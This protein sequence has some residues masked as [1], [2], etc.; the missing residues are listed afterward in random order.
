MIKKKNGLWSE[1]KAKELFAF[2]EE[3]KL[4]H[5]P[6]IKAFDNYAAKTGRKQ[7]SVRNYYYFHLRHLEKKPEEATQLGVSLQVH[8]KKVAKKFN[9]QEEQKLLSDIAALRKEGKS[10]RKAC[11]ILA[12]NDIS[13]MIRLQNKVRQLFKK[14]AISSSQKVIQMPQKKNMV[15]E[16]EISSLFVGLVKMVQKNA[17]HMAESKIEHE[18]QRMIAQLKQAEQTAQAKQHEIDMLK[19]QTLKATA[20]S[21]NNQSL[22]RESK[23][24]NMLNTKGQATPTKKARANK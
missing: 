4:N 23:L 2:I 1:E 13:E 14:N 10:V 17:L 7:N 11:L 24:K 5:V 15:N 16:S 8:N 3:Q 9:R 21:A 19:K 20:Q 12:N 22:R 18:K 6:L